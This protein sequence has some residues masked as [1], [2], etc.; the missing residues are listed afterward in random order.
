MLK[1]VADTWFGL[2]STAWDGIAA[3]ATAAA[4]AAAV[5]GALLVLR[6]LKQARDLAEE[7]ARP[8]LVAMIEESAADWTL[9]DFRP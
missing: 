1:L 7:Q 3:M 8:Y 2:S 4:F 5:V 6:Q 9:A